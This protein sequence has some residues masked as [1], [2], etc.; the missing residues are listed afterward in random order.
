MKR[1]TPVPAVAALLGLLLSVSACGETT[2]EFDNV[3]VG[4]DDQGRTPRERTNS[5]FLRAVYAD[6]LGRAPETYDFTITDGTTTLLAFP[7]NEQEQLLNVLDGIG[8]STPLRDLLVAGLVVSTEVDIPDKG[9]V[10]D[11]EQFISDQFRKFLGRN[12]GVYELKAFVDEWN[13]DDAVN[14]RTIIRALLGSIE[15]RSF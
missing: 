1:L 7:L 4:D 8:D 10:D 15:Y 5:Q 12:P 2:Y 14:P 13:G 11:P 9:D 6:L 3:G